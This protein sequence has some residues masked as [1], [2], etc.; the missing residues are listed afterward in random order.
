MKALGQGVPYQLTSAAS[1]TNQPH[2][3]RVSSRRGH[4]PSHL[5]DYVCVSFNDSSNP[6][7]SGT[8]KFISNFL[9]YYNLSPP[10]Y[11]FTLSLTTNYGPN[12][13]NEACK[14]ECWNQA[15][16]IELDSLEK[17]GTLNLVDL[18]PNVKQIGCRWVYKIKHKSDGSIERFKARLIAKG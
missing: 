15:M 13:Y 2:L 3:T 16:K 18:R 14:F 5:K 7:S 4:Q 10:Q 12:I 17:T 1:A 11:H 6:S 9:S 8:P